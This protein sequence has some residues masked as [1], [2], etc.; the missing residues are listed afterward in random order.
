MESKINK[1]FGKKER[2]YQKTIHEL[3]R[4]HAD[5]LRKVLIMLQKS[6]LKT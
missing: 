5:D 2:N 4:Q 6:Y 1:K 3:N